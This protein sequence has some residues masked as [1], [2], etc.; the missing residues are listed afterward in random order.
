MTD[1]FGLEIRSEKVIP[2]ILAVPDSCQR[3]DGLDTEI[4]TACYLSMIMPG[5]VEVVYCKGKTDGDC[6]SAH[7]RIGEVDEDGVF[8]VSRFF[9]DTRAA[10]ERFKQVA[11]DED[12]PLINAAENWGGDLSEAMT[13]NNVFQLGRAEL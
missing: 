2:P 4:A 12:E 1:F 9:A 11:T 10:L 8:E 5:S 13:M 3:C 6:G 7:M